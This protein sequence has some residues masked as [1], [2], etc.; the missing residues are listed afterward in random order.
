MISKIISGGQVGV[1]RAALDFAIKHQMPYGG[2]CPKDRIAEDGIIPDFYSLIETKTTV[3]SE[4]TL[5]N[6]KHSDGTLIIYVDD[7]DSG[8]DLTHSICKKTNKPFLTQI[9]PNAFYAKEFELWLHQNNI[10]VLNIAGPRESSYPGI[11]HK[12]LE[13]MEK[14]LL[15]FCF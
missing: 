11:Y 12:T 6:I 2:W 7:F 1:D 4:R 8:T 5:L 10:K 15:P 3:Y 9:L 13:F 14:H